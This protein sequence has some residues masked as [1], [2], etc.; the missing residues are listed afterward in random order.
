MTFDDD[1]ILIRFGSGASRRYFLKDIGY[2]W[3]PPEVLEF[4]GFNFKRLRYSSI[5]DEQREKID[6][7][8]RGAE[9]V[10][11]EEYERLSKRG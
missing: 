10:T 7:V 8:C 1:H 11:E 3:P 5:T 2:D 4:S 6:R 9:Y